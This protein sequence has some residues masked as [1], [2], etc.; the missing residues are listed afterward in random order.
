MPS[1]LDMYMLVKFSF[2]TPSVII[3]LF[4]QARPTY[5]TSSD[6]CRCRQTETSFEVSSQVTVEDNEGNKYSGLWWDYGVSPEKVLASE[7]GRKAVEMAV[8][9]IA[10]VSADKGK[11]TMVVSRLVSGRLLTR[12]RVLPSPIFHRGKLNHNHTST[13]PSHHH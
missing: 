12:K 6:G 8:M 7:C 2:T 5:L 4:M 10:P 11:Y 1:F 9:Q 13:A 3:S